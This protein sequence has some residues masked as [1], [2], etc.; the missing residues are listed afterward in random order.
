MTSN[1]GPIALLCFALL[2]SSCSSKDDDNLDLRPAVTSISGTDS[3]VFEHSGTGTL[4]VNAVSSNGASMIAVLRDLPAGFT[5]AQNDL[6]L[7]A[8]FELQFNQ[9]NAT[10]FR[11]TAQVEV[12][13]PNVNA[14]S[15]T[16]TVY[17]VYR[18]NCAYNYIDHSIGQI[19]YAI[20]GIL[21]QNSISCSY[22]TEGQLEVEGLTPFT[23][24]LNINCSTGAVNMP[25]T[26]HLG[27]IITA[28]GNV[29]GNAID[30][31]F[32]NDG[33]ENA[34]ARILP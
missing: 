22:N 26:L 10:P 28:T 33:E 18:P 20:N 11:R 16:K 2:M 30:L 14:T 6:A 3:I 9:T 21:N 27:S 12:A 25:S 8:S 24:V 17:L 7:P 32:S 1:L 4:Q 5:L 34:V 31:T 19:T 15:L 29:N 13:I 23:V